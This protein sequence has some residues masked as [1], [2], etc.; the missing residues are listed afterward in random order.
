L[1][2]ALW[3]LFLFAGRRRMLSGTSGEPA[4]GMARWTERARS[5]TVW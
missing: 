1:V 2:G 4:T 5:L 3:W